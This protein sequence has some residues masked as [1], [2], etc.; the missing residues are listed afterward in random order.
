M[1]LPNTK[2]LTFKMSYV[3][4]S[5]NQINNYNCFYKY[6]LLISIQLNQK[7]YLTKSD[8]FSTYWINNNYFRKIESD[9]KPKGFPN[10]LIHK[11]SVV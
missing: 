1:F 5:Q 10:C 7:N 9:N 8:M 11:S 6:K 4:E 3:I 2:S